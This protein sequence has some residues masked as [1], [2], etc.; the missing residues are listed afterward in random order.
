MDSDVPVTIRNGGH[1]GRA[2]VNGVSQQL[3]AEN[4]PRVRRRQRDRDVGYSQA[5]TEAKHSPGS[6]RSRI[7]TFRG[8]VLPSLA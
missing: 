6:E 5:G 1:R 7:Y 2:A 4:K 3:A 8:R